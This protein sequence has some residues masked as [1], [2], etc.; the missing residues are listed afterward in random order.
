MYIQF[1]SCVHGSPSIRCTHKKPFL[2]FSG[3]KKLI[4]IHRVK[5]NIFHLISG[6]EVFVK[7]IVLGESPKNLQKPAVYRKFSHQKIRWKSLYF[8]RWMCGKGVYFSGD[9]SLEY[10][11]CHSI[12]SIEY[13]VDSSSSISEN[14]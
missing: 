5:Y 1:S 9:V 4:K 6:E 12:C 3:Q 7:Q 14:L 8:T 13:M 2:Q 10:W 11:V